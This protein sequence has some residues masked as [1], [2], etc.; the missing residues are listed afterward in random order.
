[1]PTATTTLAPSSSSP[2]NSTSIL[3][4][5]G[6]QPAAAESSTAATLRALIPR[7][8]DAFVHR[9][10]TLAQSLL[11]SAFALIS[12][13]ASAA[14]DELTPYRRKWDILRVSLEATVYASPP[15]LDDLEAFPET[16]RANQTVSPQAFVNSLYARSLQLFTP[17]TSSFN[18]NSAYLPYQV[19]CTLANAGLKIGCSDISRSIIEDWLARRVPDASEE[20]LK[21]YAKVLGVYCLDVL[22]R[23]EEWQYAEDFLQYERELS[24][25][26]RSDLISSLHEVHRHVLERRSLMQASLRSPT[27]STAPSST[28]TSRSVSPTRSTSS[29]SSTSTHTATPRTPH[30]E[31]KKGKGKA[32]DQGSLNGLTRLTPTDSRSASSDAS[33]TTAGTVTPD[34]VNKRLSQRPSPRG[35][36]DS[37]TPNGAARAD[38]L[39]PIPR[40]PRASPVSAPTVRPPSTIGLVRAYVQNI[41]GATSRPKLAALFVV[42]VVL[43]LLSVFVRVRR[44]RLVVSPGGTAEQ[45][46]R[47]LRGTQGS[48]SG[49]ATLAARVWEEAVRVVG[50]TLRMG[51]GGLA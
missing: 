29:E 24:A 28:S 49:A 10:F 3:S 4:L 21:G 22:P 12:P 50:D 36:R 11:T 47:R 8:T 2:S 43:P 20:S 14:E 40:P 1:M 23:L 5:K 45:V 16:L 35:R 9:N 15:P 37:A 13:P 25:K 39:S 26:G 30:P 42:F 41:L 18:A 7:A 44:Q 6:T 33:A 31:Q 17:S 19:V 38:G 46:R 48:S 34:S 32:V 27:S 51:G